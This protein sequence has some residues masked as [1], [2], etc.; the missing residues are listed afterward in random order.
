[1]NGNWKRAITDDEI[2]RIAQNMD[3]DGY[4]VIEDYLSSE[5]MAPLREFAEAKVREAGGEYVALV[6][7]AEVSETLLSEL[8]QS[9]EF[10]NLCQRLCKAQTKGQLPKGEFYQVLRCIQGT[11]GKDHCN[12]FHYDSYVVSAIIPVSIP[13]VGM[14]GDLMLLPNTRKIRKSYFVNMFDKFLIDNAFS[15]WALRTAVRLG[16]PGF[17]RIHMRPGN[18]YLFCGYRSIHA[19][20]GCDPDKLRATAV[21]HYGDPHKSSGA[22]QAVRDLRAKFGS[23]VPSY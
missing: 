10:S 20:E 17:A 1:M 5:E 15:Q 18:L 13:D 4:D 3:R 21:F 14:R 16:L 6:G 22:R 19:N 8:P 9:S 7:P 23:G 11:T 12:R 2:S